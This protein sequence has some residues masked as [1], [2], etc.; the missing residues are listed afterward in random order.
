GPPAAVES[1]RRR[2]CAAAGKLPERPA[3]PAAPGILAVVGSANDGAAGYAAPGLGRAWH[4]AAYRAAEY[5]G[6]EPWHRNPGLSTQQHA[7]RALWHLPDGGCGGLAALARADN[8]RA[9]RRGH[10][11]SRPG[12]GRSPG[13]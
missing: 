13:D 11:V 7:C 2:G 6:A 8:R 12:A 3:V 10:A 1:V 5:S 9:D 4:V